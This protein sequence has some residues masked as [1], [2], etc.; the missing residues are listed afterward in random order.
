MKKIRKVILEAGQNIVRSKKANKTSNL[1]L[2]KN[3]E[4][5]NKNSENLI[6]SYK[7]N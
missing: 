6:R 3:L 5:Q 4:I 7:V 1:T 2:N